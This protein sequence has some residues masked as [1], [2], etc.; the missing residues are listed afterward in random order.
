MHITRAESQNYD[1]HRWWS[2]AIGVDATRKK[3]LSSTATG[4]HRGYRRPVG[5][6][7]RVLYAAATPLAQVVSSVIIALVMLMFSGDDSGEWTGL[8]AVVV[9]LYTGPPVGLALMTTLV[10]RRQ[11]RTV[12]RALLV[13]AVAGVVSF[14]CLIGL[15]VVDIDP[16][17]SLGIVFLLSAATVAWMHGRN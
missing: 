16:R 13:G 8:I 7:R 5:R 9:G 1:A 4:L 12:P 11:G 17:A 6:S 10:G 15:I 14:A 3:V 2:P